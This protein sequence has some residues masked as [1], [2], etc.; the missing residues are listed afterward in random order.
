MHTMEETGFGG[1]R[2]PTSSTELPY[3]KCK[4]KKKGKGALYNQKKIAY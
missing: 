3:L 1:W 2:M 4:K